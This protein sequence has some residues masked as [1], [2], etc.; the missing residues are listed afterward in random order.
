MAFIDNL[1]ALFSRKTRNEASSMPSASPSISRGAP[2]GLSNVSTSTYDDFLDY[3]E[4]SIALAQSLQESFNPQNLGSPINGAGIT[5]LSLS[6]ASSSS[7]LNETLH[8]QQTGN[9]CTINSIKSIGSILSLGEFNNSEAAQDLLRQTIIAGQ[10]EAEEK[11]IRARA[12][13]EKE[14]GEGLTETESLDSLKSPVSFLDSNHLT[15]ALRHD[16]VEGV[17][18]VDVAIPYELDFPKMWSDL[19]NTNISDAAEFTAFF[20]RHSQEIM[21][22]DKIFEH[23]TSPQWQ[24][25]KRSEPGDGTYQALRASLESEV[26]HKSQV[27][28]NLSHSANISEFISRVTALD[29]NTGM[30][31]LVGNHT[32]SLTK[33][34]GRYFLYDSRDGQVHFTDPTQSESIANLVNAIV[35]R[36]GK[37]SQGYISICYWGLDASQ[38]IMPLPLPSPVVLPPLVNVPLNSNSP[39]TGLHESASLASTSQVVEKDLFAE[40]AWQWKL[41]E[42]EY[43]PVA[44]KTRVAIAALLTQVERYFDA[45]GRV[46]TDKLDSDHLTTLLWRLEYVENRHLPKL[47][48]GLT[49]NNEDQDVQDAHRKAHA[50]LLQLLL[51]TRSAI[52]LLLSE[53]GQRALAEPPSSR[54]PLTRTRS[55]YPGTSAAFNSLPGTSSVSADSPS[56]ALFSAASFR[57]VDASVPSSSRRQ[58]VA[59]P[60]ESV[61]EIAV[62][63]AKA[64]ADMLRNEQAN[65]ERYTDVIV[66]TDEPLLAAYRNKLPT[67]FRPG[68]INAAKDLSR[69]LQ[70]LIDSLRDWSS[71]LNSNQS[72][73]P[74]MPYHRGSSKVV[75]GAL[76][77]KELNEGEVKFKTYVAKCLGTIIEESREPAE[78]QPINQLIKYYHP[79]GDFEFEGSDEEQEELDKEEQTL[80]DPTVVELRRQALE[81]KYTERIHRRQERAKITPQQLEDRAKAAAKR[82]ADEREEA[83]RRNAGAD[84]DFTDIV[85]NVPEVMEVGEDGSLL[86]IPTPSTVTV[87]AP[88]GPLDAGS[89]PDVAIEDFHSF[90]K[91]EAEKPEVKGGG[92]SYSQ[93]TVH[94]NEIRYQYSDG[95]NPTLLKDMEGKGKWSQD[96]LQQLSSQPYNHRKRVTPPREEVVKTHVEHKTITC[97]LEAAKANEVPTL[98]RSRVAFALII[99]QTEQARGGHATPGMR[100]AAVIEANNYTDEAS[101]T[102]ALVENFQL[103]IEMNILP[104]IAKDDFEKVKTY[105]LQQDAKKA[106]AKTATILANL[107]MLIEKAALL[108]ANDPLKKFI[109]LQISKQYS[110]ASLANTGLLSAASRAAAPLVRLNEIYGLSCDFSAKAPLISKSAKKDADLDS[111]LTQSS[112]SMS[113]GG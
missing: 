13:L 29:N 88:S 48:K 73:Q 70:G 94:D 34:D 83:R 99:N 71:K 61:P 95:I 25:Y 11:Y 100:S 82:I 49:F 60:R 76:G 26:Q 7:G 2:L 66:I 19:D 39:S 86:S 111:I 58:K 79:A 23:G 54:R 92:D 93:F 89:L 9:S 108:D 55:A 44:P 35:A 103:A 74:G 50:E 81:K 17:A 80:L 46:L 57:S 4:Q 28:P 32:I 47:K 38:Q 5:T 78:Y 45:E 110:S 87:T 15:S 21:A 27:E 31:M 6:V 84:L 3:P 36:Y 24:S 112:S 90:R 51:D 14:A 41:R 98:S 16:R 75:T 30:T 18:H 20:Q 43:S 69:G 52:K 101:K 107:Q 77:L 104:L 113:L 37:M 105:L 63:A 91:K 96:T 8:S 42:A 68:L 109:D 62:L 65:P 67:R 85:I 10:Q 40:M 12:S 22:I 106:E 53:T 102:Q 1:L 56:S 72:L 59:Q 33:K 64:Y 97:T